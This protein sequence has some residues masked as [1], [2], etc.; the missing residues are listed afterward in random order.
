M[1]TPTN[2]DLAELL[3][4]ESESHPEGSQRRRALRRAAR[5]ALIWP[6]EAAS[7]LASG[8]RVTELASVGPWI[9]S[10]LEGWLDDPPAI[11]TPAPERLGFLTMAEARRVLDEHTDWAGAARGD[12]QMHTTWSD[13]R[14]SLEEM[15][16]AA[17]ALGR[18]YVAVTDHSKGLPIAR[19]MPEERLREQMAVIDAW[20]A[21]PP[22]PI[23][24]L[25]GLE[26]NLSPGGEGDMD[27]SSLAELDLVLGA[28]HSSLRAR[29]DQ[30][31]R[32][33]A[34]LRNPTVHV[35]AHPRGR[36]FGARVGLS[37]DWERVAAEA[38]RTGTALEVD[39]HPDRQ[40]LDV[41]TLRIVAAAGAW[42]SIGTD[43]HRPHELAHL[44]LGLAALALADFPKARVLNFLPANEILAWAER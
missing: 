24:L 13:G 10:L 11:P 27:P 17:H 23:R 15:A 34:A 43:A 32:Y 5:A 42:V 38:A 41:E 31:D 22:E 8:G 40:D 20:N 36:R 29:E 18:E 16:G 14:A 33:L 7:I 28:F 4:R 35:L 25:R 2:A 9:G 21:R 3:A 39:A 26:M 6:S 12:L 19:G 30:T 44:E 37:A 1:P